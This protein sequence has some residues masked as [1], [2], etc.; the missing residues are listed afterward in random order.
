[1]WKK[2]ANLAGSTDDASR[3]EMVASGRF[4]ETQT[5]ILAKAAAGNWDEF[6]RAY[7][8][9]CWREI[10]ITC[11]SRRIP[12][13]EADDLFQELI[14][15]LIRDGRFKQGSETDGGAARPGSVFQAN[16]PG[17]FL[18]Y[19]EVTLRS[20]R[21]RTV[22]KGVV[23]NLILEYFRKR[24]RSAKQFTKAM[25]E[26]VVE[27]SVSESADH[28]WLGECMLE[29]AAQ[30]QQESTSAATRGKQ[31]FFSILFRSTV[32]NESPG[33]I[34]ADLGLDRTTVSDLL[35]RARGRF[36]R[37]L[38]GETE[39]EDLRRLQEM[40]AQVPEMLID[41]LNQV[42]QESSD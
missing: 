35:A 15:R 25:I 5:T 8:K 33:A 11:R 37:L 19:R 18:K 41:A 7:L 3:K 40:V 38:Q 28:H 34:A 1:M 21:F 39:V 29:A 26:S 23:R 42:R 30:L 27:Q 36:V 10:E 20:A 31:R 32:R 9:P 17:K 16:V 4:P 14:L 22:V 13:E 6:L 24:K 2:A 12:L